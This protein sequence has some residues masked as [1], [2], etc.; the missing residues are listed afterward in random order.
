M[1][2]L[3][4][5]AGSGCVVVGV[6]AIVRAVRDDPVIF[7]QLVAAGVIEVLLLLVAVAAGLA[8]AS[9]HVGGDPLVLW[10]YLLT[11]LFVLPAA[12]VW[13]FADRTRTSSVAL[14]FACLTVG[15]ML[16]RVVT[17]AALV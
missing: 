8:Q 10:G 13:A 16:W 2:P 15:V 7:R 9:G 12:G 3:I 5:A 11:V 14:A 4:L 6:W 1:I 17:V